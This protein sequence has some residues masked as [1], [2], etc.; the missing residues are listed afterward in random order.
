MST[1]DNQI[2]H[3][4]LDYD[5]GQCAVC[6]SPQTHKS[7]LI[8]GHV[9]CYK[10][11]LAW[12]DLKFECPLCKQRFNS[13]YT[14]DLDRTLFN[15]PI[16]QLSEESRQKFQ[17]ILPLV[18][19]ICIDGNTIDLSQLLSNSVEFLSKIA[20]DYG[21]QLNVSGIVWDFI[22]Q[23]LPTEMNN[24]DLKASIERAGIHIEFETWVFELLS[25]IDLTIK[26]YVTCIRDWIKWMNFK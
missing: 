19:T 14:T 8:C 20:L 1:N 11:I 24:G 22:F 18:L 15:I 21:A 25:T 26:F 12:S 6:L 9:F 17:E 7:R 23:N 16:D 3:Q 13:F 10:C 5:N 4:H 2:M